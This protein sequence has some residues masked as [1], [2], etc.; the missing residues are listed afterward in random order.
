[1][2]KN[3]IR[4]MIVIMSLMVAILIRPAKA[5]IVYAIDDENVNEN[6]NDDDEENAADNAEE[7][8]IVDN[9]PPRLICS[10]TNANMIFGHKYYKGDSVC[11]N[12][13]TSD[14]S[15]DNIVIIVYREDQDD[16]G[17]IYVTEYDR[18]SVSNGQN[19][20]WIAREV[21][22][23]GIKIKAV[24]S[25]SNEA[26]N[27]I[28][29]SS[30]AFDA[31][32]PNVSIQMSEA[33]YEKGELLYFKDYQTIEIDISEESPGDSGIKTA[34]IVV[35]GMSYDLMNYSILC[36]DVY[37]DKVLHI[38]YELKLE[39]IEA[40]DNLYN[41]TFYTED[42]VGNSVTS[43]YLLC[44][45]NIA[46][47]VDE[48]VAN[49]TRLSLGGDSYNLITGDPITIEVQSSDNLGGS[50]I[51]EVQYYLDNGKEGITDNNTPGYLSIN[52][53]GF[54]SLTVNPD[55]KGRL[56]IRLVDN[57]GNESEWFKTDNFITESEGAFY[58]SSSID[59]DIPDT[60]YKDANGNS[61]YQNDINVKITAGEEYAGIEEVAY[62]IS[63][64]G[65]IVEAGELDISDGDKD[66]NLITLVHINVPVN[67]ESNDIVL[68]I[69]MIGNVGYKLEK[70][71]RFS[72]DK[73][74]PYVSMNITSG[75]SD[76][77]YTDYYNTDVGIDI[78]I[79]D[80]NYDENLV[81]LDINGTKEDISRYRVDLAGDYTKGG[82]YHI[83]ASEDNA[84]SMSVEVCD[85][86]RNISDKS[87]LFFYV[88]KTAPVISVTY[89]D[90]LESYY[91]NHGKKAYVHIEDDNPDME[92]IQIGS[93]NADK[94]TASFDE[95][96]V[97]SFVEE[98]KYSYYIAATD[99][100][101]N[102]SDTYYSPEFVIDT[103]NPEIS[104]INMEQGQSFNGII[105]G[106]IYIEDMYLD[107]NTIK[108]VMQSLGSN[109]R[110][111]FDHAGVSQGLEAGMAVTG[112]SSD[113]ADE[114]VIS[115]N[116]IPYEKE[117]DGRY[118]LEVKAGDK[119]GNENTLALQFNVN[120]FGSDY[121][122]EDEML[123]MQGEYLNTID[124]FYIYETNVDKLQYSKA[125]IIYNGSSILLDE[126]EYYKA[127]VYKD[128]KYEYYYAIPGDR[129]E[130]D[131]SYRVV[132]SSLDN[133]GNTNI[134][135]S[136]E[137]G[138][139]FGFYIDNTSPV[140]SS[141]YLSDGDIVEEESFDEE[142][143]IRDNG[144]LSQVVIL[145]NDEVACV[146]S[147]E[148][149]VG[150]RYTITINESGKRQNVVVRAIDKAGNI[151]ELK[152]NNLLISNNFFITTMEKS[153]EIIGIIIDI[154]GLAGLC[155]VRIKKR[156]I[157]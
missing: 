16:N 98:G 134:S 44:I 25:S 48:I 142:F 33:D 155:A 57:V 80:I 43:D 87:K 29:D 154:L 88:D 5:S 99:K 109:I 69:I 14:D 108:L 38:S 143:L 124:K 114:C 95:D 2:K 11:I 10:A 55:Y 110:W 116:D 125:Q 42:H 13:D 113:K 82:K 153:H 63:I 93:S 7:I 128:G 61:L 47:K 121:R 115:I 28:Y 74:I 45:D 92:R 72:I 19:Q 132:I 35:N 31:S 3:T 75:T 137:S 133:A 30:I 50:G 144:E 49:G 21:F 119:A 146:Y 127:Y 85:R 90:N 112:T 81:Y 15:N 37:E 39:D 36:D 129:F 106:D 83:T 94:I 9:T 77:S 111:T 71:I 4:L 40:P 79:S 67:F 84:Y 8:P 24:D 59:I 136:Q 91:Y 68:K 20:I 60:E 138:C 149:L 53:D 120:R 89:D 100:A 27:N 152:L 123:E 145:V 96:I 76:A 151:A 157:S 117:Y 26:V 17:N 12:V 104:I 51:R 102:I 122:L 130:A 118:E 58:D 105:E 147:A 52:E 32:S 41:I 6:S 139:A 23:P 140:I 18:R 126:S 66:E 97:L 1:M 131:G 34:Y 65:K 101:G 73:T 56:Y 141:I 70:S 62:E 148:Q 78:D 54:S 107:K 64:D 103:T 135:S 22:A 150:D 156:R 46:P 86:A